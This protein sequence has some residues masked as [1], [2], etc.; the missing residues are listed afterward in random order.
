M[1]EK[2]T[3]PFRPL[4]VQN[5]IPKKGYYTCAITAAGFKDVPY[6]GVLWVE[7]TIPRGKYAGFQLK[8]NFNPK[9]K[10]EIRLS[11]LLKAVRIDILE[12]PDQLVGH[13]LQLRI[14][15][16]WNPYTKNYQYP[17]TRFHPS[18]KR[19]Y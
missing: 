13:E 8:T 17:I 16:K 6:D 15:R 7:F 19:K 5:N 10:G 18:G 4:R 3:L 1:N 9:F 11:H 14:L 2:L 12:S